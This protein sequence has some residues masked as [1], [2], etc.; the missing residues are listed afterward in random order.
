MGA[1]SSND[2]L[3]ALVEQADRQGFP[4]VIVRRLESPWTEKLGGSWMRQFCRSGP[5]GH[6]IGQGW[7]FIGAS[8]TL[9]GAVEKAS[10]SLAHLPPGPPASAGS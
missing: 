10:S 3:S 1:E 9:A 5:D 6:S 2:S 4:I 7:D 8:E